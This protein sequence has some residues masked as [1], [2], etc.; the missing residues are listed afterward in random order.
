MPY[1]IAY[2]QDYSD[3]MRRRPSLERLYEL[4]SYRPKYRLKR[5]IF[6]LIHGVRRV[7]EAA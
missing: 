6:D 1:R 3:I 2:G 5:T 7:V 4:C